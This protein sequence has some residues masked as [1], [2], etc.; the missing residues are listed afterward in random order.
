MGGRSY[1][2]ANQVWRDALSIDWHGE[3]ADAL[4]SVTHADMMTTGAVADQ[5]QAHGSPG[6]VIKEMLFL[7]RWPPSWHNGALAKPPAAAVA[8][9]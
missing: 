7:G 2:V 3:A 8:P 9:P 4:R 6:S 1:G 5:L